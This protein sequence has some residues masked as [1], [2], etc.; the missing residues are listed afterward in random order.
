LRPPK[1]IAA[2]AVIPYQ[3]H[4]H[5][6]VLVE[7]SGQ[8]PEGPNNPKI[9]QIIYFPQQSQ[10]RPLS[11]CRIAD[12]DCDCKQR[13]RRQDRS[14][15]RLAR[16]VGWS[17]KTIIA[18]PQPIY[19]T[20]RKETALSMTICTPIHTS[21]TTPAAREAAQAQYMF[22][23]GL[24]KSGKDHEGPANKPYATTNGYIPTKIKSNE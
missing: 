1:W 5:I 11:G 15:A 22:L 3:P 8:M 21:N 12:D 9:R 19:R 4:G 20:C 14:R 6:R 17:V 7:E 16:T 23:K 18:M 10:V 2:K 13:H 24:T